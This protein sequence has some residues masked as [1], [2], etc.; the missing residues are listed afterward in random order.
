[1]AFVRRPE[2]LL[3][4]VFLLVRKVRALF[5]KG[6]VLLKRSMAFA[7]SQSSVCE[8]IHG[9]SP[10]RLEAV[11]E[12][13]SALQE[14]GAP[15]RERKNLFEEGHGLHDLAESL[16]QQRPWVYHDGDAAIPTSRS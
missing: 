16:M 13:I 1:M 12:V 14:H 9:H 15:F 6:K 2:A 7:V 11:E 10:G 4:S 3:R 5:E 8:Y